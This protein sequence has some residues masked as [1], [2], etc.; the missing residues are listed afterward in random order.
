MMEQPVDELLDSVMDDDP[1]D[2][3]D[4]VSEP[5]KRID[6]DSILDSIVPQ[7]ID[8]RGTVGRHPLGSVLCVGLV[9]YL[10]GR[11]KGASIMAGLTAGL[12][13][14]MMRQLSDVFEGDF[15]DY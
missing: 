13:A 4:D 1:I 15:F 8:W 5:A 2:D 6:A 9:G 10:V 7:T 11:T 14:A 12:S 3:L